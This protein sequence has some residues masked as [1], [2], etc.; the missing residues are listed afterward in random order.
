[1]IGRARLRI[2]VRSSHPADEGIGLAAVGRCA[3]RGLEV[4]RSTVGNLLRR[5]GG[6]AARNGEFDGIGSGGIAAVTAAGAVALRG[7]RIV[8]RNARAQKLEGQLRI[9]DEHV[10]HA[11]DGLHSVVAPHLPSVDGI[12]SQP[13]QQDCAAFHDPGAAETK[14]R[15]A[16]ADQVLE[17]QPRDI[18]VQTLPKLVGIITADAF[19]VGVV[20]AAAVLR[21]GGR[22]QHHDVVLIRAVQTLAVRPCVLPVPRFAAVPGRA[23]ERRGIERGDLVGILLAIGILIQRPRAV[24]A[25]FRGL[26]C[27]QHIMKRRAECTV[28]DRIGARRGRAG[29]GRK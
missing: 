17:D 5:R 11:G 10:A 7:S 18:A 4:D 29:L 24:I 27:S 3:G 26:L 28:I 9:V 20:A 13:F 19:A 21:D 6:H 8:R 23:D 2:L 22:T 12:L 14:L 16:P 1:M 15:I 25:G